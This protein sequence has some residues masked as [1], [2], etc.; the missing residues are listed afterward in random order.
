[1]VAIVSSIDF[2][3]DDQ[4][5]G[6]YP[7]EFSA[8]KDYTAAYIPEVRQYREMSQCTPR[9]NHM[10]RFAVSKSFDI[11][12]ALC[13]LCLMS[14]CVVMP[15]QIP[16]ALGSMFGSC[17]HGLTSFVHSS[18]AMKKQR[19]TLIKCRVVKGCRYRHQRVIYRKYFGRF[20][21]ACFL[22]KVCFVIGALGVA[23]AWQMPRCVLNKLAHVLNGNGGPSSSVKG[24]GKGS[25]KGKAKG[26]VPTQQAQ[27]AQPFQHVE[28]PQQLNDMHAIVKSQEEAKKDQDLRNKM[29]SAL[30]AAAWAHTK[31]PN[32]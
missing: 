14:A 8:S 19:R 1:M 30:P 21:F 15:D 31:L 5:R 12:F 28:S 23:Y 32:T 4:S 26:C 9:V 24:R 6:F 13:I 22:M 16:F 29:K 10:T 27:Q 17:I 2:P 7:K 25:S 3:W 20:R 18:I 11:S